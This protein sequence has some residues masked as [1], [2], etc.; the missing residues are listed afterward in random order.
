MIY[1]KHQTPKENRE[2]RPFHLCIMP[3]KST[4]ATAKA[5]LSRVSKEKPDS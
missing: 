5:S 1:P 2:T 4:P 3:N